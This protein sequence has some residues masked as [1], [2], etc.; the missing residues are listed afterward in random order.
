MKDIEI[1]PMG[2]KDIPQVVEIENE[3][4]S[5]PWSEESFQT[6]MNNPDNL[7]Y[8]AKC[9]ECVVGYVGVW[10]MP[11]EGEVCNVAVAPGYRGRHIGKNLMQAAVRLA[12][13]KGMTSLFLEVRASNAAAKHLYK[14]L[15]FQETGVRR[16]YY[17]AP[18]EDAVLMQ[19]QN[20]P[21]DI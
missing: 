7:Y 14:G 20:L 16:G 11:P 15:G 19:L 6:A 13:K 3:I 12:A 21:L 5:R 4:F 10:G 8:V 17:H 2:A 18:V 1:F 9:G